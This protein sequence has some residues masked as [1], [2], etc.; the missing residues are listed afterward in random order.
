MKSLFCYKEFGPYVAENGEPLKGF[1][2]TWIR[3]ELTK[4]HL[5]TNVVCYGAY[6]YVGEGKTGVQ[7]FS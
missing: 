2:E 6:V 4:V 3:L 7:E 1:K 5:G